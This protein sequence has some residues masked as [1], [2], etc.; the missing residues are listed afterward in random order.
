ME[1]IEWKRRRERN[2]RETDKCK[3][4]KKGAKVKK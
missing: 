2:K 3:Q 4:V 1:H